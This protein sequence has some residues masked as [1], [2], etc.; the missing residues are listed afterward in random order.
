MDAAYKQLLTKQGYKFIGEHSACKTCHYTSNSIK[1][2]T[3]CYKNK[4]YGIESHRCVQMSVAVNF[5]N[6][7]CVFCWRKRNNSEF[8][9]IDDPKKLAED[10]IRA[11][12]TL[13]AGFGGNS[14][15]D[16]KKWQES[17]IPLHVA[18]SLNGES[19]AYPHLGEFISELHGMGRTTF[20]VTNGQLPEVIEKITPPTQLYISLSAPNAELFKMIDR[21]LFKDGWERL[22]RSFDVMNKLRAD[23]KTRTVIRL[24]LIR[25][26]VMEESHAEEF[27]ELIKRANPMFLEIKGYSWLGSSK[28][29]LENTNMPTYDEIKQFGEKIS[30]Y[31]DYKFMDGQQEGRVVLMMQDEI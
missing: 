31:C 14:Q 3:S 21:P 18:I 20:L 27:A 8:G 17:K 22:L 13:L 29:R 23:G 11:Q 25:D 2:K 19:T 16:R 9:K 4:F 7:D 5:C 12:K 26:K 10:A 30:Q 6:L 28:E 15:V 1:G 24:T